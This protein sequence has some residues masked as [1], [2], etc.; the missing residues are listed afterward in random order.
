M[1]L[2]SG[3]EQ[4]TARS[5]A[6][7]HLAPSPRPSIELRQ[8]KH[9]DTESDT[10]CVGVRGNNLGEFSTKGNRAQVVSPEARRL[11]EI[12]YGSLCLALFL[13][14]WN[15][16]TNGPLIPRIRRY[17]DVSSFVA[18]CL[19]HSYPITR[20]STSP[21]SPSSLSPTAW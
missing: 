16:S 19:L 1:S 5:L 2:A 4:Q 6:S 10:K 17:Y 7:V 13:A 14:G 15:D 18:S 3:I 12:Q 8:V 20:R 11:L 9:T 21:S